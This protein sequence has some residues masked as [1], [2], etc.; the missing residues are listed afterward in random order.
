M[1]WAE[2]EFSDNLSLYQQFE[3]EPEDLSE[4]IYQ[5]MLREVVDR[6]ERE[7]DNRF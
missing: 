5:Q 2:M 3:T 1:I 7:N 4:Y 6:F